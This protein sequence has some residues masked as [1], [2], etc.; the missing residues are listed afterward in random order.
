MVPFYV[1]LHIVIGRHRHQASALHE[2][3][4]A[5]LSLRYARQL[6]HRWHARPHPKR[7]HPGDGRDRFSHERRGIQDEA[8][9]L[10]D[11]NATQ[12]LYQ[13]QPH[14]GRSVST[15]TAFSVET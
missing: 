10:S 6:Q 7:A 4:H 9:R 14:A 15:S 12:E 8:Q 2:R 5:A 11:E 3:R 1:F 13:I